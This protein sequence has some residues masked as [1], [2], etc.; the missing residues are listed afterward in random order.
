[1]VAQLREEAGPH[2]IQVTLQSSSFSFCALRSSCGVF[3]QQPYPWL[4]YLVIHSPPGGPPSVQWSLDPSPFVSLI[5]ATA[6]TTLEAPQMAAA[7]P[8]CP[9]TGLSPGHLAFK[10]WPAPE[11]PELSVLCY[12]NPRD[13]RNQ[14]RRCDRNHTEGRL[15]NTPHWRTSLRW[16][17]YGCRPPQPHIMVERKACLAKW[18]ADGK[19]LCTLGDSHMRYLARGLQH[20]TDSEV[21][22]ELKPYGSDPMDDFKHVDLRMDHVTYLLDLW[23]GTRLR[24]VS[25]G[26]FNECSVVYADDAFRA[27]DLPVLDWW[28]PAASLLEATGDSAHF[29]EAGPHLIQVTLQS[30]SF[31]FCA[32]R[33]SCGVLRQQP[34]PWLGYLVIHSPPGGPP[35]VQWSLDPSPFVSLINATAPT[36]LEAPQMAAAAPVCPATGLSPGHLAFKRWPAPE[37][38]ELSVLCYY[39]PRDARNQE[40]RC[41]RNHTEGRLYNTPHWRTSLR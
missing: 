26:K 14:E 38:P 11:V 2:L 34:Y 6:P 25:R 20:W 33:S 35:S 24:E 30:S 29:Q 9:A 12:Y 28:A 31:S 17:P 36:T 1:M 10:R 13:A 7:A 27:R 5:N 18:L 21:G 16:V 15:Y 37:V 4:G 40:R 8:V 39:N 32:L 3:T 22:Q 23:G 19:R 41:D